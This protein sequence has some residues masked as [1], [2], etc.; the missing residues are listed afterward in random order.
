VILF[1]LVEGV[2]WDNVLQERFLHGVCVCV[3]RTLQGLFW[4][5]YRIHVNTPIS[6]VILW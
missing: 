2:L 4:R 6:C 3:W 1:W 5:R